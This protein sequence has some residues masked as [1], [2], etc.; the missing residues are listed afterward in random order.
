MGIFSCFSTEG[1]EEVHNRPKSISIEEETRIHENEQKITDLSATLDKERKEKEEILEKH[2]SQEVQW[3]QAASEL[4][5]EEKKELIRAHE[6]ELKQLTNA[7]KEVKTKFSNEMDEKDS[8]LID[9]EKELEVIKNDKESLLRQHKEEQDAMKLMMSEIKNELSESKKRSQ[10]E[11][12]QK[13]SIEEMKVALTKLKNEKE[14]LVIN[15]IHDIQ[16]LQQTCEEKMYGER[17]D[18]AQKFETLREEIEQSGN[19][20][21]ADSPEKYMKK[22]IEK[23]SLLKLETAKLGWQVRSSEKKHLVANNTS[24]TPLGSP[25]KTLFSNNSSSEK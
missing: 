5:Q 19:K 4:I 12:I 15:H 20:D 2:A 7:L 18:F 24:K 17:E 11:T 8:L 1:V 23:N 25:A 6:T 14:I 13:E 21:H 22:L 16:K 3:K 10:D 9:L